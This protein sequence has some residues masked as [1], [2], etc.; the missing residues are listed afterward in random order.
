MLEFLQDL[1]LADLIRRS[2]WAFPAIEVVHL[3]GIAL[4][5]GMILVVD[6]AL[7]G[8][9]RAPSLKEAIPSLLAI[10]KTG[11]LLVAISGALLFISDP[12]ELWNN[13]AFRLKI[14]AFVIAIFNALLF[15]SYLAEKQKTGVG[16]VLRKMSIGSSLVLWSGI[17]VLGRAIAY[18]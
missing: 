18:V 13:P 2:T 6:L 10:T 9:L 17:L 1:P 16:S 11:I 3:V 14:I 12:L 8:V 4:L 15:Q 5:F 7:L